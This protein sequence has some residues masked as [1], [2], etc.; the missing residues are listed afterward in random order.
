MSS[1]STSPL[2]LPATIAARLSRG[3]F[4]IIDKPRGPSS[5]QVT[6]WVRDLLRVPRAGHAGTLDPNVSGVLWVG[7]GSALKLLPLVLEFPKR[8]V[9]LVTLHAPTSRERV[10][11]TL[12]E[13]EGPVYQTPPLRSAVRRERRIRRIHHLRLV[14]MEGVDLLLDVTADSGTYV[15]TLAV[16]LGEAMGVGAHMAELRRVATGPFTEDVALSLS[17]LADALARASSGDAL[18]LE[19]SLHDPSEV[20]GQFPQVVLRDGAASAVAHGASLAFGGISRLVGTFSAGGHVVMVDRSGTLV[21]YGRARVDAA[22]IAR[23]RHGWIVET[24]R[25]LAD[26]SQYP[27]G[28]RKSDRPSSPGRVPGAA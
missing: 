6:A 2:A 25:V 15:R 3:A 17:T 18:A 28:W 1:A 27:V 13:F 12:R 26:P 20:W 9:A 24:E 19:A 22:E 11:A 16:D 23:H 5:H 14:E 7:V 21:G 10:A 4:L 8:Y